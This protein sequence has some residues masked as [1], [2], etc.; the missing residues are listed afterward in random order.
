MYSEDFEH[1][2]TNL[3][4]KSRTSTDRYTNTV[5]FNE[6]DWKT[7][8]AKTVQEAEALASQGFTK[9]DIIG[10]THLYRKLRF[11]RSCISRF[12]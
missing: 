8:R 12:F 5:V 6:L 11:D 3:G 9:Y 1:K 2:K 4:H 10:E 7:A